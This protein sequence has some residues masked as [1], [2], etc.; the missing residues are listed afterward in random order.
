[1]NSDR[2]AMNWH[3]GQRVK[4]SLVMCVPY[5]RREPKF[6]ILTNVGWWIEK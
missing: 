5:V 3:D 4:S 1:M 2:M 6:E